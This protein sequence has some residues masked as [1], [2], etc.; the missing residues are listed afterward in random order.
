M[1]ERRKGLSAAA[2]IAG[3]DSRTAAI[4]GGTVGGGVGAAVVAATVY[5]CWRLHR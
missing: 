4:V 2:N 3:L 1:V 5:V